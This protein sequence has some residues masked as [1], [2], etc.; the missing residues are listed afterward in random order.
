MDQGKDQRKWSE[1]MR[2]DIKREMDRREGLGEVNEISEEKTSGTL[3]IG[4]PEDMQVYW[5]DSNE[6]YWCEIIQKRLDKEGVMNA[7][8][9]EMRQVHQ[10]DV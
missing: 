5:V 10:H 2:D 4:E 1:V 9:E 7:R 8:L 6:E 3:I